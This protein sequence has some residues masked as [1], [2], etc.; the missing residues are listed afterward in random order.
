MKKGE[1]EDGAESGSDVDSDNAASEEE[2]DYSGAGRCVRI[3][4]IAPFV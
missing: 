4:S 1:G 2:D 3:M